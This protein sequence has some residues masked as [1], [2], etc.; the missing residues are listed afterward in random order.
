MKTYTV[1][2]M[3]IEMQKNTLVRSTALI[4]AVLFALAGAHKSLAQI[5][6]SLPNLTGGLNN[7]VS[8]PVE[9]GS[10]TGQNAFSYDL[11]IT[12]DPAIVEIN[13]VEISGTVSSGMQV[14]PNILP[15]EITV[16]AASGSAL[17]GSGTLIFLEAMYVGEGTSDLTFTFFRFNEGIPTSITSDG[18]VSVYDNQPPTANNVNV[19][20]NEDTPVS[21]QLTGSDPEGLNLQFAI[22]AQPTNGSLGVLNITSATTATVTYTPGANFSGLDSFQFSVSDGENTTTATVSITVAGLND[23]PDAVNDAYDVV[24][25]QMLMVNAANGVLANDTDAEG[26]PLTASLVT[27]VSH[28]TLDLDSDGS[29]TYDPDPDFSGTDTFIYEASDGNTADDATVTITVSNVNDAPPASTILSPADGAN[30]TIGGPAGG[31]PVDGGSTLLTVTWSSAADPDGDPVSYLY[32]LASDLG[33]NDVL[34]SRTFLSAAGVSLTVAEVADLYDQ[35]VSKTSATAVFHR[36][37]T[38]DGVLTT[39]G[40]PA[41][42]N[43]TRGLVTGNESELELPEAFALQGNYPNPFNPSTSIIMD[44]PEA[45]EVRVYVIDLLGRHVLELPARTLEAGSNRSILLDASSLVSGTYVYR[46]VARMAESQEVSEGTLTLV[47]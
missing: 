13:S 38:S 16:S 47:K 33:F 4:I 35:A 41:S 44:L 32:E 5:S 23:T 26:V 20:T 17:T 1:L 43:L 27:D 7:L 12:Y 45:T 31:T 28:G 22:V 18:S 11:T 15:G 42:L 21:I 40:Y 39:V 24:E 29:F 2:R 34:F 46:V 8:I 3:V 10:L 37:T 6:V 14:V 25:D 19:G 9:V 36:V 30:L